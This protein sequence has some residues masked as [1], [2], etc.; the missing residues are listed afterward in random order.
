M[1][2]P[3]P[4]TLAIPVFIITVVLEWWLV[5]AGRLNGRYDT[6]DALVS[7]AMGLGSVVVD[8]LLAGV[9]LWMLMLFWP[10]RL[11]EVPVTWWSFLLVFVGYDFIYYW[12]HRFAHTVRW[13]WAEH[14]THHSSEH[15]NL[16]TALRQPWFGPLTGL[17]LISAPLVMLGFHPAFIAFSGGVNLLYQY[18]IHTEAIGRMPGWFEWLLN[19]PS[20]H[21]VHHATNPRYLDA[22]FAGVFMIWDRMFGSYVPELDSD[23]PVYGT[24]KP[25]G[26]FNPVIVAYHELFA[27]LA[28]CWRDGPRPWR[29]I[30]RFAAAP[31]WSPT[32]DHMRSKELKAAYIAAHPD[33]AGTPGLPPKPAKAK[34]TPAPVPAE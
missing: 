6:K 16:T 25:L 9:G 3:S 5:K 2:F 21:R 8:T 24:V 14:V 12:K 31:G 10:Y 33:Q 7:L 23:K 11:F 20:N 32:G 19:S 1:D 28:D 34:P 29:W 18:W 4:T 26:K 13:F 22:N 17:I 27:I 30:G 15:Y